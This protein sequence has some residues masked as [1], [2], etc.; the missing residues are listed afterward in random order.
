MDT[1]L[2]SEFGILRQTISNYLQMHYDPTHHSVTE[3]LIRLE[4]AL[5]LAARSA[6]R[7]YH[8]PNFERRGT[9]PQVRNDLASE[10]RPPL[11][12]E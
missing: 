6:L 1:L 5:S 11:L 9:W 12:V 3:A 2:L 8:R 10:W 4:M 7:G